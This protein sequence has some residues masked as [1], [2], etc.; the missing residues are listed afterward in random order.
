M[1]I[2]FIVLQINFNVLDY[3]IF[4]N[5]TLPNAIRLLFQSTQYPFSVNFIPETID[6]AE[7]LSLGGIISSG[8]IY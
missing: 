4:E 1:F 5:G 3:S 8:T 6:A 7:A 2:L